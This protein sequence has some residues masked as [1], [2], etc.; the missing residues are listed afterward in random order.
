VVGGGGVIVQALVAGV[1]STLPAV[2]MAR[3]ASWWSAGAS[4][5]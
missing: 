4:P 3:T 2:S 1:G 5:W